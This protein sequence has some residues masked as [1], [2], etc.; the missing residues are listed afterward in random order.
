M[1]PNEPIKKSSESQPHTPSLLF[2]PEHSTAFYTFL[3]ILLKMKQELGLEAMLEYM[4]K[5]LR[6]IDSHNPNIA[7]V[8]GKA[9]NSIPVEVIFNELSKHEKTN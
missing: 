3:S 4:E 8:V 2:P 1:N 7:N 9:L 5:Y 6:T